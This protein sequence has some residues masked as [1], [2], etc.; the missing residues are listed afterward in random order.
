MVGTICGVAGAR[1]IASFTTEL[2]YAHARRQSRGRLKG[3][4]GAPVSKPAL[5][6]QS[7]QIIPLVRGRPKPAGKPALEFG[8]FPLIGAKKD[9]GS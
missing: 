7:L 4:V 5:R 9:G 3:N 8:S 6:A 2:Y 1:E